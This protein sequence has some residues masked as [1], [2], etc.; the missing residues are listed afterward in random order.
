MAEE[1]LRLR[2]TV[3]SDEAL[4]NIRAIG[5]EIGMIPRHAGRGV[6]Q[7]NREFQ[8]LGQ[9][10]RR[11]GSELKTAIP[12]FGGFTLGAAGVGLAAVGLV[13]SLNDV[14]KKIVELKYASRELGISEQA[15]RGFST[16]AEKAGI[17]SEQMMQG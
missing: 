11:V 1:V 5:R 12:G 13:R 10:I 6:Q 16:A 14:S 9:T 7:V 17:S 4:A 8:T 15:L 3:V 2:T